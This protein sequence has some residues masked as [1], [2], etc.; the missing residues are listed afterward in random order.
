MTKIKIAYI[1]WE[2]TSGVQGSMS[3][4]AAQKEGPLIMRT[5]G[6]LVREDEE[7]VSVAQDTWDWIGG[8][9]EPHTTMRELE[10]IP[11]GM[12]RRLEIIDV[13]PDEFRFLGLTT[14]GEPA[15]VASDWTP[16]VYSTPPGVSTDGHGRVFETQDSLLGHDGPGSVTS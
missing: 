3:L 14:I 12:V 13:V 5:S 8:E 4:S 2:D 10:V 15:R 7:A 16:V 11:R 9:G 1:E 6:I